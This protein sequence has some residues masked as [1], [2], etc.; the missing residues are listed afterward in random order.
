VAT[1]KA[2]FLAHYY[3][4]KSRP[5]HAYAFGM[6]DRWAE[7]GSK[8]PG[9]A[10]FFSSAPGFRQ[11]LQSI[12]H[13]APQRKMPQLA[14]SSFQGLM[15]RR[16]YPASGG[17]VDPSE[18]VA[19][20][21][22]VILW[23]DTFNNYFHPET[24]LAAEE[25]LQGAGFRVTVPDVH[26]CCGR[27]LYDFGLLDKAKEYLE[28]IMSVLGAQIDAGIPVVVLE[29][30]CASV[31]K[32]ELRNLFPLNARATKLR[33]QTFLLSEFLEH[34]APGYAPPQLSAKVLLHGHCHHK[35]LMGMSDEE[36][37]LRKMGAEVQSIDSGCC[38][39]AG[40]FGFEK[41]KYEVSQ[42]V[43]E[44]VLLPAVRNTHEDALIVSDGFS[45]REQILQSTGRR[46]IHLAEAL[47]LGL[48]NK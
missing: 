5:L 20:R 2:E 39:M 26:L 46:A 28:K 1:Y 47:Q 44:R 35:S 16:E 17:V 21:P 15:R 29:P 38:G 27:P 24:S 31:F 11:I 18:K 3:E 42:A 23:M 13:L 36:S 8:V 14:P 7:L 4:N 48:K 25:V 9:L 32:D 33:S 43:G 19:V 40:P 22:E 41:D 12:L 6:I 30:S 10:D 45:C 34:H 37:V